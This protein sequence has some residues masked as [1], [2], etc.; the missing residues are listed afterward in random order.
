MT[1]EQAAMRR[2]AHDNLQHELLGALIKL[3]DAVRTTKPEHAGYLEL[4]RQE[5]SA[6]IAKATT[7][8]AA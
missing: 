1:A 7:G 5:A 2:A 3:E 8:S 4:C 6:T